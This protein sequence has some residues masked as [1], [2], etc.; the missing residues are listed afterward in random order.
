MEYSK[1]PSN[2]FQTLVIGAGVLLTDFDPSNATLVR[3][4]IL[5]A[6]T[7]GLNFK[8]TP[9]FKDFGEDID[10]CPK[11]TKEL[12][13]L[14]DWDVK[15]SGTLLSATPAAARYLAALADLTAASGKITPRDTLDLTS[16]TGDFRTL[17]L[18]ADYSDKNTGSGA[19]FI[20]IKIMNA[21]STGGFQLQTADK[22]KGKFAF[23]LTGHY[24]VDA[25]DTVPFEIYVVGGTNSSAT[26][27][28]RLAD[29]VINLVVN[30]TQTINVAQLTPANATITWTSG[31]QAKA[32]VDSSGKV[33]AV[34]AGSSI[35][36]ASITDSGVTYTDTCTVVVS[37]S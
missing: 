23:E 17:W 16:G 25:Q 14:D 15:L 24:S 20:A 4:N 18:V 1:Y 10:N 28:I 33:T 8:A 34:A 21:L 12:K 5:G 6:T 3:S 32:T 37:A 35:I 30:G 19:G 29:K 9:S 2:T 22:D 31:T 27:T 7:G 13:R 11:N 26:P 36:T